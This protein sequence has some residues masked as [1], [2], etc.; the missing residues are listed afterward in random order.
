MSRSKDIG[1]AFESACCRYLQMNGF[2]T[3]ERRALAGAYDKGDLLITIGVVGSCKA[4]K[5]AETATFHQLQI[6]M[7]EARHQMH[8]S[9]ASHCV[10]LVKRSGIGDAKFGQVWACTAHMYTGHVQVQT[11][12]SWIR[13]YREDGHGDEY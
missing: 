13:Q 2:G 5:M 1:T 4:G 6:W 9:K 7:N 11:L 12:D 3:C 8:N 10:L